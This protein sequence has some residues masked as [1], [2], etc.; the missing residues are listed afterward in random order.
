[1]EPLVVRS[2][3][4]GGNGT[5]AVTDHDEWDG[6]DDGGDDRIGRKRDRLARLLSVASILYSKGK[7][8]AG[9]AVGEIARLTGMTTRTVYRDI[10]ALEDELAVPVFQAARGHYGIDRKFFLPPL[11]LSVPEAIVLFLAS[12]LIARWSDQYDAAVV[13]AFTKLADALPQPIA[14]HVAATMLSVGEHDTNEPFTRTFSAVARGWAEGRVVEIT[15]DPGTGQEKRTRVQP[16]ALEPDAALRSVY[17]IGFDEPANAMRTY[18]VERIQSATLTQDRYEIPDGFDPDRWL[19]NSWGIWSSDSTPPERVRLRFDASVAHRVREAVW[20]RSQELTELD[21]GGVELA[22]TVA[23]IIEIRP[24][25]LSWGDGVEVLEPP[26][27]ARGGGGGGAQRGRALCRLRSRRSSAPT[28]RG[29]SRRWRSSESL[30]R[31]VLGPAR[32]VDETDR[33]LDTDDG[34]LAAALWACRLRSREGTTRI[35]LKGPQRSRPDDRVVAPPTTGGR[36][37]RDRRDRAG[38]L[39]AQRGPRPAR[40]PWP[41]AAR[42]RSACAF[43]SAGPSERSRSTAAHRSARSRSTACGSPPAPPI[44]VSC[45]SWSSSSTPRPS[46]A[47]R[48]FTDWPTRWRRFPGSSPSPARSWSTPC[49]AFTADDANRPASPADAR[50]VAGHRRAGWPCSGTWAGTARCGTRASSCC[51]T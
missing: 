18:K 15:Y 13:S 29:R 44:W 33:Y 39:A 32:T 14:R 38:I 36:R 20:H 30:G 47:R 23:G 16:Y 34:R 51:C 27:A 8:D 22:V 1:M 3:A 35:S 37:A 31:A 12:R 48:S 41:P 6:W 26:V 42:W 28:V 19:A 25:I 50:G 21:G 4:S 2:I 45:S 11:R 10:R 40:R 5:D 49:I 43:S 46:A 9:V 24:W 7:G 17:L